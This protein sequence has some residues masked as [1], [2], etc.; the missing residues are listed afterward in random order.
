MGNNIPRQVVMDYSRKLAECDPAN[1]VSTSVPDLT[2][3][4]DE[5]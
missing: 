5:V 1:M 2:F 4:S 3:P